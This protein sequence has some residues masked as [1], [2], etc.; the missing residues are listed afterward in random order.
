MISVR[1]I[2]PRP[3][4]FLPGRSPH[5]RDSDH[6]VETSRQRDA[7]DR[8]GTAGGGERQRLRALVLGEEPLP[9]PGLEGVGEEEEDARRDTSSGS[10]LAS[11]QPEFDE[12]QDRSAWP[13]ISA[14][15]MKIALSRCGLSA[16]RRDD[17]LSPCE[18]ISGSF[19][20]G[21]RTE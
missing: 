10:A 6:L 19:L 15:E 2:A 1:Q 7:S 17:E 3:A 20:G 21:W 4:V 11:G 9:A 5:D 14:P 16:N 18:E 8:G 12:M 13:R